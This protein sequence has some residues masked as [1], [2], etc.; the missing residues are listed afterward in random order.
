MKENFPIFYEEYYLLMQK[1]IIL[2]GTLDES[3][4]YGLTFSVNIFNR[5]VNKMGASKGKWAHSNF[6]QNKK[7]IQNAP[8]Y[9]RSIFCLFICGSVA[10]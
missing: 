2:E 5:K 6:N 9:I 8:K 7:Q 10:F 1:G 3:S 4:L